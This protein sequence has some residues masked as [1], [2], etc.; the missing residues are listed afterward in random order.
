MNNKI[1][2]GKL[3][4]SPGKIILEDDGSGWCDDCGRRVAKIWT[5]PAPTPP[6]TAQLDTQRSWIS[7]LREILAKAGGGV[8]GSSEQPAPPPPT[9]P[10]WHRFRIGRR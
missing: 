4:T 2:D 1:D 9:P 6:T 3:C 10:V 7:R 5:W 8:I